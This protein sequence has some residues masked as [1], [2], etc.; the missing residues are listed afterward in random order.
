[1]DGFIFLK[2]KYLWQKNNILMVLSRVLIC[3][4]KKKKVIV[5]FYPTCLFAK[6]LRAANLVIDSGL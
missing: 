3:L 4:T 1:M 5:Q 6:S 2:R